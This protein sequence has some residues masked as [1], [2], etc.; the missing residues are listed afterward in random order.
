MNETATEQG[1]NPIYLKLD[2]IILLL[3]VLIENQGEKGGYIWTIP[4]EEGED[5]EGV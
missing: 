3:E 4:P 5:A 2:K 1:L